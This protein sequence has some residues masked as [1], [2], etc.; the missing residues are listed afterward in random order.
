MTEKEYYEKQAKLMADVIIILGGILTTIMSIGAITGADEHDVCRRQPAQ[1][2]NRMLAGHGLHAR[3]YLDGIY[4]GIASFI[5][6]WRDSGLH[7]VVGL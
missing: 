5:L 4:D 3:S 2:R 6:F 7:G 1:T